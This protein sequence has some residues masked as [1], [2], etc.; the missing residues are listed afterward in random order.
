MIRTLALVGALAL[1]SCAPAPVTD[2]TPGATQTLTAAECTARGGQMRPV[3]RMQ[4]VRCVLRY[5]DA[6]KRCTDGAQC[7]GD[8]RVEGEATAREGDA[9]VGRCQIENVRFGC[10]TTIANGRAQATLCID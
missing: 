7:Q 2:E 5:A 4:S 1:A 8:C 9:V 3:G 6:G 10:F